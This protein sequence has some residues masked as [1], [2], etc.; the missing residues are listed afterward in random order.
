MD[1]RRRLHQA[2]ENLADLVPP[3]AGQEG[4]DRGSGIETVAAE[5]RLA[6]LGR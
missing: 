2:G 6:R 4:D 5:K 3:A 1:E